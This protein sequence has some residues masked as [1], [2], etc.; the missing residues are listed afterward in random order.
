MSLSLS[1]VQHTW[2]YCSSLSVGLRHYPLKVSPPVPFQDVQVPWL[3]LS[4][5]TPLS[6]F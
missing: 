2:L 4:L 3:W 5:F 6:T 1:T